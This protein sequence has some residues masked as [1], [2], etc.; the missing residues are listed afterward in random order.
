VKS[1]ALELRSGESRIHP[2]CVANFG[3]D[4][5]TGTGLGVYLGK[6]KNYSR[7]QTLHKL[8]QDSCAEFKAKPL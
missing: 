8:E 6:S 2:L 1:N 5:P 4:A 3:W 7:M